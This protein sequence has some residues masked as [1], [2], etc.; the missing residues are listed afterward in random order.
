MT[1]VLKVRKGDTMSTIAIPFKITVKALKTANPGIDPS[2]LKPG[3]T[4]QIPAQ[5]PDDKKTAPCQPQALLDLEKL[6][7]C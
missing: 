6:H 2:N 7:S 1:H 4:L 5:K 3:R